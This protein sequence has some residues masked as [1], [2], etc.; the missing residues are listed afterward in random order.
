MERYIIGA[1]VALSAIYLIARGIRA[2]NRKSNCD[3]CTGKCSTRD[4]CGKQE[5]KKNK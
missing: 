2:W 1:L 5:E 4:C 3:A